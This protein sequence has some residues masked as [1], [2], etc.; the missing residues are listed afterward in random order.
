MC[1]MLQVWRHFQT[2]GGSLPKPLFRVLRCFVPET[3]WGERA[4]RERQQALQQLARDA[5]RDAAAAA[6]GEPFQQ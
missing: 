1:C 2:Y 3:N 6:T 4:Q 5:A